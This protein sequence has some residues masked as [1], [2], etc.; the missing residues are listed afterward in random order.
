MY[1]PANSLDLNI[2]D[3][4]FFS[5]I[6]ALRYKD[7]PKIIDELIGAVETRYETCSP[8]LSNRIFCTLQGC[9]VEILKVSGS[10]KYIIPHIK[11]NILQRYGQLPR[12]LQCDAKLVK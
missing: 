5:A 7:I 4:G 12:Q 8:K 11:K 1:Q 6:Q 2:L 10:N 3:L 9:M